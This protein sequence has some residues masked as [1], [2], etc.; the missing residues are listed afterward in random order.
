MRKSK[1]I[2]VVLLFIIAIAG[3][4]VASQRSFTCNTFT[5]QNGS[6]VNYI[7]DY[8]NTI[9]GKTY[10]V[11]G[12]VYSLTSSRTFYNSTKNYFFDDGKTNYPLE[13]YLPNEENPASYRL[14]TNYT[15]NTDACASCHSTHTAVG[16][17]LLQW[18]SVYETCM[19]CHDGTVTTTYNV[20]NGNIGTS[21]SP[22]YGGH[23]GMGTE[24]SLSSHNVTSAVQIAAAPGGS[25]VKETLSRDN[26]QTYDAW[27]NTFGCESCH[28]PHG[29]GGNAR[30]LN[31][32][33]NGYA[34]KTKTKIYKVA[35]LE[36][37]AYHY[38]YDPTTNEKVL[39][40]KGYP[41]T[42]KFYD[43][44]MVEFTPP[45]E[46]V[47]SNL[48]VD[49][50]VGSFTYLYNALTPNATIGAV[51]IKA[52]ASVKVRMQ[53]TN[54]L[55]SDENIKHISGIN[56]F[57]GACHVD[58]NT[59]DEVIAGNGKDKI[60][61]EESKRPGYGNLNG[62]YS[63][64]HR[65]AVGV[66]WDYGN[67]A[68]K[69]YIGFDNKLMMTEGTGEEGKD[70]TGSNNAS[71]ISCLTCHFA[72]GASEE[73]WQRWVS[74]FPKLIDD[75]WG[76][77]LPLT[78]IAGSSALKRLPNMATCEACH[79][80][81]D[82]AQGYLANTTATY[83][84]DAT[85]TN[86][87]FTADADYVNE[88][89]SFYDCT[90]GGCH[91]QMENGNKVYDIN[92]KTNHIKTVNGVTRECQNCHGPASN[93]FVSPSALNIMNPSR[94]GYLDSVYKV[95][96]QSDCHD[97]IHDVQ[98]NGISNKVTE[99][100]EMSKH[101][102]YSNTNCISCHESHTGG[103]KELKYGSSPAACGKC[104]TANVYTPV[105]YVL[106]KLN[107]DGTIK[108]NTVNG[109]VYKQDHSFI[110]G[111]NQDPA[112]SNK[113]EL[114]VLGNI[115]K[116][117]NSKLDPS[118]R[119]SAREEA[120][121]NNLTEHEAFSP[122]IAVS[123]CYDSGVGRCHAGGLDPTSVDHLP[124]R[125]AYES[126]F[127]SVHFSKAGRTEGN[128]NGVANGIDN[129]P[130]GMRNRY[131]EDD[132]GVMEN[133]WLGILT[134]RTTPERNGTAGCAFCHIS[135]A[136]KAKLIEDDI[137]PNYSNPGVTAW[138][139]TGQSS[140]AQ[141]G[142]INSQ[143]F[144]AGG[145]PSKIY[146][147]SRRKANS[148]DC[149]MC[150]SSFYKLPGFT[151]DQ[152]KNVNEASQ[153]DKKT[154][155]N[156]ATRKADWMTDDD[157]ALYWSDIKSWKADVNDYVYAFLRPIL[158]D[159]DT[160]P[161]G[162]TVESE[163]AFA[164]I[165]KTPPN[166]ACLRCHGSIGEGCDKRGMFV[167][168]QIGPEGYQIYDVHADISCMDCHKTES[169]LAKSSYNGPGKITSTVNPPNS[170]KFAVGM[171]PDIWARDIRVSDSP[172]KDYK[173][174]NNHPTECNNSECHGNRPH[175]EKIINDHYDAPNSPIGDG[176][177]SGKIDCRTCHI[178]YQQGEK[179]KDFTRTTG[180]N[181]A[182]GLYEIY[183]EKRI[184]G[185]IID[186]ITSQLF[187]RPAL[188]WFNGL[189]NSTKT[190][191]SNNTNMNSEGAKITPFSV[192][193][194]IQIVD[195]QNNPIPLN[196]NVIYE[197]GNPFKAA[198]VAGG[199]RTEIQVEA[200]MHYTPYSG[201]QGTLK[202]VVKYTYYLMGHGVKTDRMKVYKQR[203]AVC[204]NQNPDS[205]INFQEL[206]YTPSEAEYLKE[207]LLS[208]E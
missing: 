75:G 60:M 4:A 207:V 172:G 126:F 89:D 6:V 40:I 47:I 191:P 45:A 136:W 25:T 170:H 44:N 140:F 85:T 113:A 192:E 180:V 95:C 59:E 194:T 119:K 29:Q 175:K 137:I 32:D 168:S 23:F 112:A 124:R 171:S 71:Y 48:G 30:I 19:A 177:P 108:D 103:S 156:A 22:T 150:H 5:Y 105:S 127:Q 154:L 130:K 188:K 164:S 21:G 91:A 174:R 68:N 206:G 11:G 79:Q 144:Y 90:K 54:Y 160:R 41:Y 178:P 27:T 139:G 70:G 81:G 123:G 63:S 10:N 58:Y 99:R 20:E 122:Q 51:Y 52:T 190:G 102:R 146:N 65:H 67:A 101:F 205:A 49:P 39:L 166:E 3:N 109:V 77:T 76:N 8:G 200:N 148:I 187:E 118:R 116:A 151:S 24:N 26:G 12:A 149:M 17:S 133:N 135:G 36:T 132:A 82:A 86:G 78:E 183:T 163:L 120:G 16:P 202:T 7:Y 66:K 128:D 9:I 203:C 165:Y 117:A 38:V 98:S 87:I 56:S 115:W 125:W 131:S 182:T 193:K 138:T 134:N 197:E 107:F 104:H 2:A 152:Y 74:K 33:P 88:N 111:D 141:L 62:Q 185:N 159:D 184:N 84:Q 147:D 157:K 37:T 169:D 96:G 106:S 145:T 69:D 94:L 15:K 64:A 155:F 57:C 204:H 153:Y 61:D 18:Y 189:S 31:P 83:N 186:G 14:H 28:S 162:V 93:H 50:T 42:M 72:H 198:S 97:N 55:Q 196:L 167:K 201:S 73:I 114:G 208:K 199:V 173:N 92:N 181:P 110:F 129:E 176:K 100:W 1:L 53:E 13:I 35:N 161:T 158:Q 121:S 43:T 195:N 179:L 34:T 46:R 143:L 142:L 80:K